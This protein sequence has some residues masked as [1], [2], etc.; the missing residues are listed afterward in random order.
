[1]GSASRPKPSCW[2]PFSADIRPDTITAALWFSPAGYDGI[3]C[4]LPFAHCID[5]DLAALLLAADQDS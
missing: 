5:L 2:A 4:S 1:M 3:A